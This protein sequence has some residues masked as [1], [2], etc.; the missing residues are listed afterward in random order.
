MII[1]VLT[2]VLIKGSNLSQNPLLLLHL[3]YMSGVARE[4]SLYCTF[5][6]LTVDEGT[7]VD[8]NPSEAFVYAP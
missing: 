3:G 6:G 5:H 7:K 2:S 8:P 4:P 1:S